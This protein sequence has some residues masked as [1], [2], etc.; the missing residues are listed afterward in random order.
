MHDF[1][2]LGEIF[3]LE[4]Y[5]R[6]AWRV[7]LSFFPR[8]RSAT[9]PADEVRRRRKWYH[10]KELTEAHKT[11]SLD[12]GCSAWLAVHPGVSRCTQIRELP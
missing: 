2:G 11:I 12:F 4:S 9:A 6:L 5:P 10:S 3:G 8:T 7:T 1:L